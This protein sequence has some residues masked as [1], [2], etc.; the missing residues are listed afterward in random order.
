MGMTM[1]ESVLLV[2]S[3]SAAL[4]HIAADAEVPGGM[5]SNS[6]ELSTNRFSWTTHTC[7]LEN[8]Y[9]DTL[10]TRAGG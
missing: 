1:T 6:Y 10:S 7:A 8:V 2:E 9:R 3:V 4:E 5:A